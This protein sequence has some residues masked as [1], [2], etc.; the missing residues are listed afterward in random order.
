MTTLLSAGDSFTWGNDL[1][2]CSARNFSKCSWAANTAAYFAFSHRCIALPGGSNQAICRRTIAETQNLLN[3]GEKVAVAVMW[4]YP[5]RLEIVPKNND[6]VTV[7]HWHGLDFDT[8]VSMWKLTEGEREFFKRQHEH[9]E[10]IGI[11][12]V[13]R[14]YHKV[15]SGETYTM[16]TLK[17]QLMLRLFL[18]KNNV[19]YIFTWACNDCILDNMRTKNGDILAFKEL[20]SD[21]KWPTI[22]KGFVE[23]AQDGRY[24]V[25]GTN[26]PLEAAHWDYAQEVV[27]PQFMS[28]V[29]GAA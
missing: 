22:K 26:H 20:L 3:K 4:T 17:S 29:I 10:T 28:T 14:T 18:E 23:W 8:Q 12:E 13:S 5:S 2:D 6:F 19:P 21:V 11:A 1:T 25:G 9:H 7:S 27:I 16:E 24:P 15:L